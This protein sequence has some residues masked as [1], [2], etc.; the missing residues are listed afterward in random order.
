MSDENKQLLL[1]LME[2][3][4]NRGN[5]AAADGTVADEFVNHA[6]GP[7]GERGP[8]GFTAP[9]LWLR[10]AFPDLHARLEQSIAEGDLVVGRLTITGTHHGE[11]LG[12]P[13]T[14]RS[15]SVQ[16]IHIYRIVGGRL[17]EH[18]ACRDDLG[19][20]LQLGLVVMPEASQTDR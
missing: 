11:Y 3:V 1:H 18:W 6:A 17:T 9:A 2:E 13:P 5:I 7:N 4:F 12:V 19:Q 8:A 20:L 16:H 10:A 14:G 15:F